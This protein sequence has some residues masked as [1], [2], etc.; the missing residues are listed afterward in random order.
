MVVYA[1]YLGQLSCSINTVPVG[2]NLTCYGSYTTR[3]QDFDSG[4]ALVFQATAYSPAAAALQV[5]SNP[6]SINVRQN[7]KLTVDIVAPACTASGES[8]E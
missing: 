6:V 1:T 4:N 2:S 7:P 8:S 3:D 5:S